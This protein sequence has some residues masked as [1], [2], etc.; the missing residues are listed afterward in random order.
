VFVVDES[1]A[2]D[3]QKE[4][5]M[6]RLHFVAAFVLALAVST[7]FAPQ[8]FAAK[9]IPLVCNWAPTYSGVGVFGDAGDGTGVYSHN[10]AKVQCY[11]GV[12][13]RDVDMVTYNS[14]RTLRFVF[15]AVSNDPEGVNGSGLPFRL[16]AEVDLFGIN[17]WGRFIDMADG[18]TAQVQMD[19]EFHDPTSSPPRTFELDYS[20]LVAVRNGNTWTIS[21]EAADDPY[22]VVKDR[23]SV[24]KLNEIRRRGSIPYGTVNMPIR[25]TVTLK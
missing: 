8:A 1:P 6:K 3:G 18:S 10:V 15:D 19:L 13:A 5:E 2:W 16:N 9:A 11:F 14:G 21:S 22:N 25:F 24:A 7:A 20:A 17:Y 23:S 12:N 4:F